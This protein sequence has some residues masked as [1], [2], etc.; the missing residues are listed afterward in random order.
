MGYSTILDVIGSIIIGAAIALVAIGTSGTVGKLSFT[1]GMETTV[2]KNMAA[3]VLTIE[4]DLRKIGYCADPDTFTLFAWAIRSAGEHQLTFL[5]DLDFNKRMDTI[6]YYV[7]EQTELNFTSNPR[8]FPLYRVVN[9][10][11]PVPLN[12]GLTQFDFKFFNATG[13]Q[14]SFPID[15]DSSD[16]ASAATGIFGIELTIL[17]ESPDAWDSLY[18]YSYWRQLRLTSKNLT[19]DR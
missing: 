2:Q 16:M 13:T 3:V 7:G 18:A 17:M 1:N 19:R 9:S 15:T 14:L 11:R 6:R 12:V 5:A 4:S 10:Q 8:D